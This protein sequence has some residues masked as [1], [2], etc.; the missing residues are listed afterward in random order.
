M[1]RFVCDLELLLASVPGDLPAG[2]DLRYEGTYD[3]IKEARFEDDDSL[4]RGIWERPLKRADWN[5]VAGIA[6]ETVATRSK[7]LQIC[8][9]LMEAWI[10]LHGFDG[11]K[12]GFRLLQGICDQYWDS[13]YPSLEDPEYRISVVDW[14]DD[15]LTMAMKFVP[16]TMPVLDGDRVYSWWDWENACFKEQAARQQPPSAKKNTKEKEVIVTPAMIEQA[17]TNSPAEFV[18]GLYALLNEILDLSAALN[19]TFDE[20]FSVNSPSVRKF[21]TLLSSIRD[22]IHPQL[23]RFIAQS[24]AMVPAAPLSA[25]GMVSET[26]GQPAPLAMAAAAGAGANVMSTTA[27]TTAP[28]EISPGPLGPIRSRAEAYQR[29]AEAADFLQRTEPHSPTPYLVRRAI[30]WG[31]M[32]LRELLPHLIR[33]DHALLE[34]AQ[35]LN[36]SPAPNSEK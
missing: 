13:M 32:D 22:W 23:V 20:K 31:N 24:V 28:Q 25:T 2:Q 9:W 35:L 12:Q 5:E 15:K 3:R 4:A 17:M 16:I 27:I 10:H 8:A 36:I 30:Q 29:L 7:D 34:V 26:A 6:Q 18:Q 1:D 11:A 21:R 33:N 14:V 19:K